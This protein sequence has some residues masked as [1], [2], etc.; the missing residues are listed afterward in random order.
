MAKRPKKTKT[1]RVK[2]GGKA[3]RSGKDA[4]TGLYWEVDMGDPSRKAKLQSD[5]TY[6]LPE[7]KENRLGIEMGDIIAMEEEY[8]LSDKYFAI[9][10]KTQRQDGS[11]SIQRIVYQGQFGFEKGRLKSATLTSRAEENAYTQVAGAMDISGYINIPFSEFTLNDPSSLREWVE[12]NAS[13]SFRQVANYGYSQNQGN[14][15]EGNSADRDALARFGEGRFFQ[16]GWW[17][18]PFSPNLI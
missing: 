11:G 14:Y 10:T 1:P 17:Q 5:R 8:E 7:I 12:I 3:E 15:Y 16:E 13:R 2:G 9:T 6:N 18:D 4:V